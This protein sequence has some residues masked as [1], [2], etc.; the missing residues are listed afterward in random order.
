M[1]TPR[2]EIRSF[3]VLTERLLP[4][5]SPQ[6]PSEPRKTLTPYRQASVTLPAPPWR[7]G[8]HGLS[9]RTPYSR[10]QGA[11]ETLSPRGFHHTSAAHHAVCSEGNTWGSP[12]VLVASP[13]RGEDRGIIAPPHPLFSLTLVLIYR[14]PWL[15]CRA[16]LIQQGP[17]VPQEPRQVAVAR[18]GE[19]HRVDRQRF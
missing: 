12:C 2:T 3:S 9:Y 4:Y 7:G 15:V 1:T 16:G 13:R 10:F 19:S 6:A 11:R 5:P 14:H 8:Y 17:Q 18:D